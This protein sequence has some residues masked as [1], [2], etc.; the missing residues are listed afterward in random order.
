[1]KKMNWIAKLAI[2]LCNYAIF[3]YV[4][5]SMKSLEKSRKYMD[6]VDKLQK[7]KAD[8]IKRLK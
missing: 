8:W 2:K 7:E 6:K 5:L 1:M 4:I 3:R